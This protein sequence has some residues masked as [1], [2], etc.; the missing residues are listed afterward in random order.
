VLVVSFLGFVV[1][2]LFL[3]AVG[4]SLLAL[5]G[6]YLCGVDHSFPSFLACPV[7]ARVGVAK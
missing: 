4:V 1:R 6:A 2:L 7:P 5:L 3:A